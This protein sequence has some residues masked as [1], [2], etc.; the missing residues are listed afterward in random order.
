MRRAGLAH[1]LGDDGTEVTVAIDPDQDASAF[2]SVVLRFLARHPAIEHNPVIVL[3]ESY[4]AGFWTALA[5]IL[6]GLSLGLP[7][8]WRR[9]VEG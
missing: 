9:R 6:V 2:V 1:Q 7:G 8:G 4:G 5:M 3:G